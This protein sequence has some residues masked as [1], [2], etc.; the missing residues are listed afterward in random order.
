V[1]IQL[2][3]SIAQSSA[4]SKIDELYEELMVLGFPGRVIIENSQKHWNDSI[5]TFSFDGKKEG[6]SLVV[7]ISGTVTVSDSDAVLNCIIPNIATSFFD[8]DEIRE[9]IIDKIEKLFA[10]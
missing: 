1:K 3:H 4:I 2:S 6:W 9:H 5:M 10:S 8:E 7:C